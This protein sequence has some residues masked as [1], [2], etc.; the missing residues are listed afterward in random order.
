MS[1]IYGY[2]VVTIPKEKLLEHQIATLKTKLLNVNQRLEEKEK[3]LS[4]IRNTL[5]NCQRP[6]LYIC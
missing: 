6:F 4:D 3:E 5:P 1:G 2:L